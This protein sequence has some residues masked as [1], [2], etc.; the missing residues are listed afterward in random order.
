MLTDKCSSIAANLRPLTLEVDNTTRYVV[1]QFDC[2]VTNLCITT[3]SNS[4]ND[5]NNYTVSLKN[6]TR[7]ILNIL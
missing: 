4:K 7:I 5:Y 2:K 3:T 1:V 6:E